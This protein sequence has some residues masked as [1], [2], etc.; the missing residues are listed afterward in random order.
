[1]IKIT[2]VLGAFVEAQLRAAEWEAE[3]QAGFFGPLAL[4]E[5][6]QA[7]LAMAPEERAQMAPDEQAR[8]GEH[9]Q[10]MQ[11]FG[12][13]PGMMGGQTPPGG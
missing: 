2:D 9:A 11:A 7:F 8:M 10:R 4:A 6:V 1:M 5:Q 12:M 13:Q 3:F